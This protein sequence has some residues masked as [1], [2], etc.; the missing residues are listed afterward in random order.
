MPGADAKH[1][2]GSRHSVFQPV[3][4]PSS[5][6]VGLVVAAVLIAYGNA[7]ANGFVWDDLYLVVGNPAIKDWTRAPRLF[8]SDL[9]PGG[10]ASGYYRPLQALTYLVDYRSWGL[11]PFGFHLTNVALHATVAVLLYRVGVRVLGSAFAALAAAL[12]FALHPLHVEAVAY[13]A[14]RADPLAAACMLVAVLGFLRGDGRGRVVSVA[15]FCAALLA[16]ESA[17]ILPALLVLLDRAEPDRTRRPWRSYLPYAVVLAGYAFLR[18]ASVGA[19]HVT[20]ANAALPL[21]VRLLTMVDVIGRYLGLVVAPV[22]LHMERAVDPVTSPFAPR[23]VAGAL[24]VAALVVGAVW[25][26]RHNA[27]PVALGIAWFFVALVPVANVVP[28]ATF[29]AEHWLYVPLMG[30]ALA[31]GWGV[32]RAYE[33]ARLPAAIGL[34]FVVVL[35]GAL[36]ARQN[37][38]WRDARTLYE[39]LAPLAP[40]SLRVR[41]NLA[42]AYQ[43]SGDRARAR[44]AYEE[45]ARS[46]PDDPDTADAL[47]NLGNLQRDAG[48]LDAALASF[49]RALGLRPSYVAARNGRALALQALGRVDEA[50]RELTAALALEPDAATTHSNLGNL[51]F[52]RGDLARARERYVSALRLDPDFA[53]AHNN[54][55]SVYFK[56]GD[57]AA[58]EREYRAALRLRPD[59]EAIR[60]NLAIVAEPAH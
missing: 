16:R 37:L 44:A 24:A 6:H 7:L 12:L 49:D 33:R 27:W 8:T 22:G 54:L 42:Q 13:V 38:V 39:Y 58:A 43:E 48:E 59:S 45:A 30:L 57:R 19:T 17:A 53:D 52:R 47:N 1:G 50:E 55:G 10:M 20:V 60:R 51:Y 3:A 32:D 25:A 28:L 34:G 5:A 46:A 23:V 9:F 41:I 36:T 31:A 21:G 4:A 35:F 40:A 11:A 2:D 56:L 14:G 18:T 26:R 15:A 29:M